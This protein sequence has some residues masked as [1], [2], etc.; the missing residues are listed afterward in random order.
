MK[1]QY[2]F[3]TKNFKIN[4]AIELI[5]FDLYT[6]TNLFNYLYNFKLHN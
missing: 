3:T 5:L 4:L 6:Y 1:K 2:I